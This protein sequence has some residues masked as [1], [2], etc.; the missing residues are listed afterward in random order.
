MVFVDD[1]FDLVLRAHGFEGAVDA[2]AWDACF[3]RE[4]EIGEGAVFDEGV[5]EGGWVGGEAKVGKE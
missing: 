4:F 5:V 3:A 2:G 1:F